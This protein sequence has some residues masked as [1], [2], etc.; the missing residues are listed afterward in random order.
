MPEERR[1]AALQYLQEH[2]V[3]L[4]HP[5]LINVSEK[6]KIEYI[7]LNSICDRNKSN[8]LRRFDLKVSK[9][10]ASNV[11]QIAFQA[12]DREDKFKYH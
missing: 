3:F 8:T 6:R 11:Y 5:P 12:K 2:G 10:T 1:Q 9:S 4:Q 7:D